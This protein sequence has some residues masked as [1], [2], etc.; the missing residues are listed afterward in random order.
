MSCDSSGGTFDDQ[1]KAGFCYSMERGMGSL[2]SA[3]GGGC[4][5]LIACSTVARRSCGIEQMCT[6]TVTLRRATMNLRFLY[7]SFLDSFAI[8][9]S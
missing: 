3:G 6:S 9:R 4:V 2:V 8:S 1:S 5:S 7:S